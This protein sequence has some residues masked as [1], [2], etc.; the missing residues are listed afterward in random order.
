[1]PA[2]A[3]LLIRAEQQGIRF[4]PLSE[5]LPDDLSTLPQGKVV[6]GHISGREGWLGCQQ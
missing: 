3:D 1:L 6:R 2:F 5:L 4:C